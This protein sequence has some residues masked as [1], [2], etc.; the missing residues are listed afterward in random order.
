M[1]SLMKHFVLI[2][3]AITLLILNGC[4]DPCKDVACLNGG[5]CADGTCVCPEGYGGPN[6][7]STVSPCTVVDCF[8]GGTCVN[9][10]CDC[11]E[12]WTGPSC[13][14]VQLPTKLKV[15]KIT[16]VDFPQNYTDGSCWDILG[17]C[18]PDIFATITDGAT[19]TLNQNR[20]ASYTDCL[21]TN[22]PYVFDENQTSTMPFTLINVQ[23]KQF[24]FGLW[25]YDISGSDYMGGYVVSNVINEF[26]NTEIRFYDANT[27]HKI[28]FRVEV[29]WEY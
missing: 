29:E 16:V 15:T 18:E 12:G 19:A 2:A 11:P 22:G 3:M 25:D 28:D 23:D 27:T 14:T 8:N 10:I 21:T 26:P 7:E 9:G 6:C 1:K 24:S 20:T 5:A 4:K 17:I 13:E